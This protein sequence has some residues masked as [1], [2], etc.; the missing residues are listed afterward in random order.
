MKL[1]SRQNP[2]WWL[3]ADLQ[4]SVALPS[5]ILKYRPKYNF[6]SVNSVMPSLL[7]RS[8]AGWERLGTIFLRSVGLSD[9][10][11]VW[12]EGLLS[13][14]WFKAV[15]RFFTFGSGAQRCSPFWRLSHLK[16]KDVSAG[17]LSGFCFFL[18][19]SILKL[20]LRCVFLNNTIALCHSAAVWN[21]K[22]FHFGLLNS[23][24]PCKVK[25]LWWA[26]AHDQEFQP[27][28]LISLEA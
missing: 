9:V 8:C 15:K 4:F 28:L 18:L 1:K 7:L 16:W 2:K 14:S 10:G 3:F 12:K 22:T 21:M 20:A 19:V 26:G 6:V 23:G 13:L 24:N 5:F 25:E 17:L 27:A 11:R